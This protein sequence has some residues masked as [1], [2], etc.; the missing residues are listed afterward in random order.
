MLL[1]NAA[2]PPYPFIPAQ[3]AMIPPQPGRLQWPPVAA[4]VHHP[5]SEPW[6]HNII[7]PHVEHHHCKHRFTIRAVHKHPQLLI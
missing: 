4:H 1:S 7:L 5:T 6:Q 2:T 3:P